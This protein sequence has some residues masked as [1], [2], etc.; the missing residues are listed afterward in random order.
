LQ[1]EYTAKGYDFL[2]SKT[3]FFL[4]KWPL[5]TDRISKFL[6]NGLLI[7]E[8]I[9]MRYRWEKLSYKLHTYWYYRGLLDELG[10]KENLRSYLNHFPGKAKSDT[11]EIDLQMGL[12]AAERIL[13]DKRPESI[14]VKFNSQVIGEIPFKGGAEPI[15]GV[16]LRRMLAKELSKP[17]IKALSLEKLKEQH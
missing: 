16:H 12:C 5:I 13:D 3:A 17:L 4:I 1:K 15:K 2:Q 11:L 6:E 7:L 10:T 8:R 9:K 14:R